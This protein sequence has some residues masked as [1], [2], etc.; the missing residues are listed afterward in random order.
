MAL[1]FSEGSIGGDIESVNLDAARG[2][3]RQTAPTS[4]RAAEPATTR[5]DPPEPTGLERHRHRA[6][7]HGVAATRCC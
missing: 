2:V 6:V 5:R 3:L 4:R 1:I 7:E